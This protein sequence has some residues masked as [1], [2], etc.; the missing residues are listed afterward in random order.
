[1]CG[2][3]GIFESDPARPV[4]PE[5]LERMNCALTHRGPDDAGYHFEP[6]LGLGH[7]RLSII[8]LSTGQQPM[9][10]EDGTVW[11]VFNGEI[12]NFPELRNF[13]IGKGH[14]FRTHSDTE[15]IVHLYEELGEDSFARLRGMFAI[16][17]WDRSRRK[18]V[19]ARDRIG[20]KPLYYAWN[21]GRLVF[22]SE[23]KAILAAGGIDRSIDL[24]A[25]ADYFSCLYVPAPKSIYSQIKKLRPA[26]YL[27]ASAEGIR[28]QEYWD[29]RFTGIEE[30]S[31]QQ[32]SGELREALSDAVKVR[33]ISEVPLGSFLSGGID[34]SAVVATMSR[35]M[36]Q[37]V[38]TC[39]VG[40][41]EE[42]FNEVQYARQVAS[43]VH[44]DYHEVT[45]RPNAVEILERL[46]WHYDEPFADS[47]A[48]PTYYVSKAAREH[49]TVALTGDGGDE[50]FAGY[51]RYVED[52]HENRLRS[53]FPAWFRHGVFGPLGRWYPRL[54]RAPRIFRGKSILQNIAN[55]PLEGYLRQVCVPTDTIRAIL[56]EDVV[57]QLGE[58]EPRERFRE[59]YRRSDGRDH[60]SKVQYLD[61]KTYLPDDICAKVDRASMAVSLEVRSP[62]LDHQFMEL[63]AQIPS[64]L[65]LHH[66]ETKYIFKEAIREML[67]PSI[68]ERRKQ[69]FGVPI[70]EWF[71]GEVK[72]L[73]YSTLF[74]TKDGI[75]N[76]S[77]LRNVWDRHQAKV[78]D[79]SGFLWGA[80]VFRQWQKLFQNGSAMPLQ[81][82]H[83]LV[84]AAR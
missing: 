7:R 60:L 21:G 47:S 23:L 73:A 52:S 68:L 53:L 78:R 72:D 40:F 65:K 44:A 62:L 63:A 67:P 3:C 9:T 13:L 8:D 84:E 57:R 19:L 70:G 5:T 64:R 27:V 61:I 77:Y 2:I 6:G 58:Y 16:A 71:R 56:S 49:V 36:D 66:G 81:P 4:L 41:E 75:L 35:I 39:A 10:N 51:R 31:E 15:T 43:H 30:K 54:E 25:L 48:I 17:L 12:Y 74:D 76:Q 37:P 18:L 11:I 29:L 46:A 82:K 22:G 33:L 20:K 80:F 55:D 45:V 69:G 59:Y 1:M 83:A 26:H 34:S 38:T 79:L 32:W 50:N 14:Q 28:E 24:T 42:G